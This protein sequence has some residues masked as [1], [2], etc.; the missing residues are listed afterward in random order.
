MRRTSR[1]TGWILPALFGIK[2]ENELFNWSSAIILGT[3][4]ILIWVAACDSGIIFL[5]ILFSCY[6]GIHEEKE[7]LY[8]SWNESFSLMYMTQISV[9]LFDMIFRKT[10]KQWKQCTYIFQNLNVTHRTNLKNTHEACLVPGILRIDEYV[11]QVTTMLLPSLYDKFWIELPFDMVNS[12][13]VKREFL[14]LWV[15]SLGL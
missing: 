3:H 6:A 2:K 7:T 12:G 11:D 4:S 5:L 1:P 14:E 10:E 9:S 15:M 13:F 8:L